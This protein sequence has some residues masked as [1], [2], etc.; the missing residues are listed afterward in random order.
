MVH[1]VVGSRGVK[2]EKVNRPTVGMETSTS[3]WMYFCQRWESYRGVC[4]LHGTNIQR[5][6]CECCEASLCQ[7]LHRQFAGDPTIQMEEEILTAMETLSIN[8][9]NTMVS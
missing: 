7:A 8:L 5:Q 9:E 4:S 3:E 1:A 6:L 2:P